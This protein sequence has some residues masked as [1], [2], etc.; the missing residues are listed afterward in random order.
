MEAES[1]TWN[2]QIALGEELTSY[3]VHERT[4]AVRKNRSPKASKIR[5]AESPGPLPERGALETLSRFALPSLRTN[6]STKFILFN[7]RPR[8]GNEPTRFYA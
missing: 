1:Y 3:K 7:L 4:T 6:S 5:T 2:L 8:P